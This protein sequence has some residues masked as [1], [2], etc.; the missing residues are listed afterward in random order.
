MKIIENQRKSSVFLRFKGESSLIELLA[1][2][3]AD[4][5][6]FAS[7]APRRSPQVR[8]RTGLTPLALAVCPGLQAPQRTRALRAII[9]I[10]AELNASTTRSGRD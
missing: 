9:E 7:G 2:A 8:S 4:P 3:R 10:R 5:E 1:A 6:A